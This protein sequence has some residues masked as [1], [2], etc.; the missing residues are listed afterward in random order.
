MWKADTTNQ[1][2]AGQ[3]PFRDGKL[4]FWG[5]NRVSGYLFYKYPGTMMATVDFESMG[6]WSA[7]HQAGEHGHSALKLVWD[8]TVFH[9]D[10]EDEFDYNAMEFV[11]QGHVHTIMWAGLVFNHVATNQSHLLGSSPGKSG[12]GKQYIKAV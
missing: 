5:D 1:R 12:K 7:H 9:E 2:L 4:E 6:N 3:L 10:G 8:M 11:T